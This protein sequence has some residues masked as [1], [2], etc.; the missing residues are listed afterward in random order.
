[1]ASA[2]LEPPPPPSIRNDEETTDDDCVAVALPR[3][4]VDGADASPRV[5]VV[6]VVVVVA[7][8]VARGAMCR[9]IEC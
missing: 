9:A 8:M 6:V 5:V 4:G 1:L 7:D 3:A 2:P